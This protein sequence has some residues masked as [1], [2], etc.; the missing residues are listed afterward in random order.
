VN[1][2][3]GIG[4][5]LA[6]AFRAPVKITVGSNVSEVSRTNVDQREDRGRIDVR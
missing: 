5:D 2:Q 4:A 1:F 3:A 6:V